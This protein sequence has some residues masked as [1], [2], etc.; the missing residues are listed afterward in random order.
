VLVDRLGHVIELLGVLPD[1][2]EELH[3]LPC[4]VRTLE[5]RDVVR[6]RRSPLVTEVSRRE[7]LDREVCGDRID[8][9]HGLHRS[10]RAVRPEGHLLPHPLGALA[11]DGA[12]G[13]LV[14]Q[15]DLELRPI[16]ARHVAVAH[17][18]LTPL[19]GRLVRRLRGVEGRSR[20][21]ELQLLDLRQLPLQR[22]E[23]EDGERRGG[24][25]QPRPRLHLGLQVVSEQLVD[26]VDDAHSGLTTIGGA[27]RRSA[28]ATHPVVDLAHLELPESTDLVSRHALVSD[29]DVDRLLGDPKMNGDVVGRQP[30][31]AHESTALTSS[32]EVIAQSLS[33]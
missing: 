9:C 12:L 1:L 26:V 17:L 4:L 32:D 2:V 19:R 16:Q 18:E 15:P 10:T 24:D 21:D 29:P 23:R 28:A 7:A 30:G 20:E 13:Q 8:C 25:A 33:A 31:L 22:L 5:L 3:E 11:C 6:D 14:P 27:V